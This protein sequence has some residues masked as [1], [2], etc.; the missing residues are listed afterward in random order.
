MRSWVQTPLEAG[1]L[2]WNFPQNGV[3]GA[4]VNKLKPVLPDDMEGHDRL[5]SA[6]AYQGCKK[7]TAL[8][9]GLGFTPVVVHSS[10]Y[11]RSSS[12]AARPYVRTRAS[13]EHRTTLRDA[14]VLV[15]R[16][17]HGTCV[18]AVVETTR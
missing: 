7:S 15:V 16:A 5:G 8:F 11:V 3:D 14:G 6:R 10:S 18:L 12:F 9:L 2:K 13:Y 17:L 1:F 4:V